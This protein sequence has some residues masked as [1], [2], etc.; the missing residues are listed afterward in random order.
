M[1]IRSRDPRVQGEHPFGAIAAAVRGRFEELGERGVELERHRFDVIAQRVPGTEAV[2]ARDHR[3][4]LMQGGRLARL[5][6]FFRLTLELVEI[7]TGGELLRCHKASMLNAGGPQAGQHGDS[8]AGNS[9]K[10]WTQSFAR[11]RVRPERAGTM[12]R[13]RPAVKQPL[14]P[15]SSRPV[16]GRSC[17]R[18]PRPRSR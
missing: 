8:R 6:K 13:G 3:L 7:G 9:M 15:S 14:N 12:E 11:T 1:K 10:G 5:E 4:R 16:H 2:R 17:P 18:P